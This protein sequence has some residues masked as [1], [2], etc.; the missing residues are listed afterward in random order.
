MNGVRREHCFLCEMPTGRAGRGED[1]LYNDAGAGPFC[2]SCWDETLCRSC[3]GTGTI[4]VRRNSRGDVD[5]IDGARTNETTR[6]DMCHGE[7]YR[8]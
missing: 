6:C 1:S 4:F 5:Y 8:V 2:E 3:E 7:G